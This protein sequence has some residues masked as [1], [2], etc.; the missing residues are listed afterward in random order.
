[1]LA[2]LKKSTELFIVEG[3]KFVIRVQMVMSV[4]QILKE[5]MFLPMS[6]CKVSE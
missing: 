5:S 4:F 2:G 1:M 6:V 3:F